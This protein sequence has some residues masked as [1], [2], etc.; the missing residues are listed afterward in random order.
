[1]SLSF[2]C[3]QIEF[4][5][6][7]FDEALRLRDLVLRKPLNMSFDPEDIAKEYDSYHIACY[8]NVTSELLACLILKPISNS[9][10]KMRQV[11]VHPD[12]QSIGLGSF[13]V[14]ESE[15]FA[16]R[17]GYSK[18]E[19]N[20]RETAV[21]FYKKAGY[22]VDGDVFKEVGIDHYFMWKSI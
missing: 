16:K 7:E 4:G 1:M 10:L 13:L 17:S 8:H 19:L 6:P 2:A 20:A 3:I 11:A 5:T 15:I 18:I 21:N 12:F 9:T 14:S 22:T